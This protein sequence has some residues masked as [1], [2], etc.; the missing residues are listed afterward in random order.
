M[1]SCSFRIITTQ[2]IN[3]FMQIFV[4]NGNTFPVS[5]CET[6]ANHHPLHRSSVTTSTKSPWPSSQILTMNA[7]HVCSG[8]FEMGDS[9]QL[10]L[11][12]LNYF[13]I[14]PQYSP[15]EILY[16]DWKQLFSII[17]KVNLYFKWKVHFVAFLFATYYDVVYL[18][19]LTNSDSIC[20]LHIRGF[21]SVKLVLKSL[22]QTFQIA[23]TALKVR[24]SS[25][26]S[27]SLLFE[28]W[29]YRKF[30]KII[31]LDIWNYWWKWGDNRYFPFRSKSDIDL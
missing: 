6:G 21:T 1:P 26:W 29:S 15:E 18:N 11:Q 4:K 30:L 12:D 3:T 24:F 7:M 9:R 28:N 20:K 14:T 17:A 10:K 19:M 16:T 2:N 5:D 22:D 23:F 27:H 8:E 13:C 31:P 25:P